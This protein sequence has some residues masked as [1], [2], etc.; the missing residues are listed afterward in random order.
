M[1]FHVGK[2]MDAMGFLFFSRLLLRDF[3][4]LQRLCEVHDVLFRKDI[5]LFLGTKEKS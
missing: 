3:T 2:Y 5:T 4:A 1:G